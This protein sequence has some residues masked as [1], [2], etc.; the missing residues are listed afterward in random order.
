MKGIPWLRSK[1]PGLE[2]KHN[3]PPSYLLLGVCLT[4]IVLASFFP[5]PSAYCATIIAFAAVIIALI[6][7]FMRKPLLFFLLPFVFTLSYCRQSIH[8]PQKLFLPLPGDSV[9]ITGSV[10]RVVE[11]HHTIAVTIK[12]SVWTP[13]FLSNST[14][15]QIRFPKNL[16]IQEGD[17]L[18]VQGSVHKI[19]GITP[20]ITGNT[21]TITPSDSPFIQWKLIL[22]RHAKNHIQK[23]F[24]RAPQLAAILEMMLLG[25]KRESGYIRDIFIKTGVY[26]IL[27]VSGLHL[28]YVALFLKL[29]LFPFRAIITARFRF[30]NL[31]LIA[32]LFCYAWMTG[33][34]TPVVRAWI[35]CATFLF[36]EMMLRPVQ[37]FESLVFSALLI[38]LVAPLE[39]TKTGFLLSFSATIGILLFLRRLPRISFLPRWFDLLLKTSFGAQTAVLPVITGSFGLFYPISFIANLVLVPLG[40]IVLLLGLIFLLT[41]PLSLLVLPFLNASLSLFWFA[42]KTCSEYSKP[43]YLHTG[44]L[45]VLLFYLIFLTIT[46]GKKWKT[47][48]KFTSF[49]A[50]AILVIMPFQSQPLPVSGYLTAQEE[51][52]GIILFP[53]SKLAF[54]LEQ[55]AVR[56]ILCGTS[57]PDDSMLEILS[58]SWKPFT[59]LFPRTTHDLIGIA[60]LFSQNQ[61]LSAVY[62]SLET[63]RHPAFWYRKLYFLDPR[64]IQQKYLEPFS[65]PRE[66][67]ILF[68]SSS[69]LV[70]RS[71]HRGKSLLLAEHINAKLL[72]TLNLSDQGTLLIALRVSPS[73]K[74]AKM[75]EE[76]NIS[77]IA[78]NVGTIKAKNPYLFTWTSLGKEAVKIH[79]YQGE[80]KVDPWN[81]Q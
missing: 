4:G 45:F 67:E 18:T 63:R 28:A 3:I 2:N 32:I 69:N 13:L 17:T 71:F 31:A 37:G 29:L 33:F 6:T 58:Y 15:A 40:G 27:I 42:T 43:L 30:F 53:S 23:G 68:S 54:S 65:S 74:L 34:N 39:L 79:W 52:P 73:K 48:L 46:A 66:I 81:K 55:S 8:S 57:W 49:F 19:L 61:R 7:L 21:W 14:I 70:V 41:G 76:K 16:E 44:P 10:V 78:R 38:L 72:E 25:E 36:C 64:G 62:D 60:D 59:V 56:T 20:I 5:V 47:M 22:L 75:L 51:S 1:V 50:G 77:L 35:M 9:A 11:S 80:W 24:V 12:N 26:H